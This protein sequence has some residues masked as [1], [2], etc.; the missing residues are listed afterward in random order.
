MRKGRSE[1]LGVCCSLAA[2]RLNVQDVQRRREVVEAVESEGTGP[3]EESVWWLTVSGAAANVFSR[4]Q[5]DENAIL[6]QLMRE[7]WQ[8]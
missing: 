2:V 4:A 5:H 1:R 7:L 3:P 6:H 8:F